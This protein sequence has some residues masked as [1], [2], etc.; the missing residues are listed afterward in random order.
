MAEC[1][2]SML[3]MRME[4]SGVTVRTRYSPAGREW[5][6][7]EK[8][9]GMSSFASDETPFFECFGFRWVFPAPNSHPFDGQSSAVEH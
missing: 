1:L 5:S 3:M 2:P 9:K 7:T 8:A 6:S 4:R